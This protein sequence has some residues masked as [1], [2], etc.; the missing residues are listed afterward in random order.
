MIVCDS[1][2]TTRLAKRNLLQVSQYD[3]TISSAPR[4]RQRHFAPCILLEAFWI[5]TV[6]PAV[7]GS[8]VAAILSLLV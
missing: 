5:F 3:G 4:F 8:P 7:A 6:M 2:A 1:A